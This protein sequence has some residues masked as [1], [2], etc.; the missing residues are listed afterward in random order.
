MYL[1]MRWI[2]FSVTF[3]NCT[4]HPNSTH[5]FP[6]LHYYHPIHVSAA[7]L[8]E[9]VLSLLPVAALAVVVALVEAAMVVVHTV[10]VGVEVDCRTGFAGSW[11]S[12]GNWRESC[13]P[14]GA[15]EV[16]GDRSSS[17]AGVEGEVA[18]EVDHMEMVVVGVDCS[19][20]KCR[21]TLP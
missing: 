15:A 3:T 11:G 14:D 4:S 6:H 21:H 17:A 5:L 12:W 19:Y 10:K 8:E 18:E 1:A 2:R 7:E 13:N 16:V 20:W 9:A